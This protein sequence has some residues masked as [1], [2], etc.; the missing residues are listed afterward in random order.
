MQDGIACLSAPDAMN[1]N[2]QLMTHPPGNDLGTHIQVSRAL[3]LR[4]M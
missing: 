1:G 4:V 2:Q 3:V